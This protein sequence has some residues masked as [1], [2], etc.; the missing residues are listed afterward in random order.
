MVT[1]DRYDQLTPRSLLRHT[2]TDMCLP[3]PASAPN[4]AA[5]S[6][7]PAG[8]PPTALGSS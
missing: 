1:V 4:D 5:H 7:V 3:L 8:M 2:R 6:S